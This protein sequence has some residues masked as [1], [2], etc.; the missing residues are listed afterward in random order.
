M[1]GEKEP[2]LVKVDPV[3][4]IQPAVNNVPTEPTVL[5]PAA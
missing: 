2:T 4:Q 3:E 1:Y 5:A